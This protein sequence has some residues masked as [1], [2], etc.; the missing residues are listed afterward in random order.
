V[1]GARPELIYISGPQTGVRAVLMNNVLVAGRS[2]QVDI[3]IREEFVSRQQAKFSLTREGW[4]V[5]NLSTTVPL[6]IN[7]RKYKPGKKILLGSGDVLAMGHQTELLFV[8]ASDDPDEVLDAYQADHAEPEPIPVPPP[9][10]V[11]AAPPA[12]APIAAEP[13][14]EE[15]PVEMA[16]IPA[17]DE[18]KELT[19][20]EI[21]A[22][23]RKAK[24]RKYVIGFGIY[25][26]LMIAGV[27]ILVT[28]KK[29]ST[30]NG[31]GRP[32]QLTGRQIE[33]ILVSPLERSPNK[34]TADRRLRQARQLFL[35][36]HAEK[37]N[38]YL[39]V[40]NYRLYKAYRRKAE[41]VF[42]PQDERNFR[43]VKSELANKIQSLY[44]SAWAYENGRRWEFAFLELEQILRYIPVEEAA[45]DLRVEED[46]IDNVLAHSRYVSE[47]LS[48]Q[49][50]R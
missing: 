12:P 14:V 3:Y 21:V 7:G 45:G 4:I 23:E 44:D 38:L 11:P 32:G 41:R 43:I 50:K 26:V 25:L 16:P 47:R 13:P 5:E 8:E 37:R 42:E 22:Q 10:P 34:V 48:K 18:L 39:C 1:S 40:L 19:A 9:S 31:K 36:R 17:D 27:A 28:L 15:E 24:V 35:N 29:G 6:R 33:K 49:K 30:D 46:L 20:E 2:P